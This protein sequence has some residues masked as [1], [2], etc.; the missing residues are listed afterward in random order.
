MPR[1]FL[2]LTL[3]LLLLATP[4]LDAARRRVV[5]L[6]EG[7]H[8]LFVP[9][10]SYVNDLFFADGSVWM[11]GEKTA[12]LTRG[13]VAIID[14]RP[15]TT[16][17]AVMTR[18]R[19]LCGSDV[20]SIRCID[21]TRV[22]RDYPLDPATDVV[23]GLADSASGD[24]WFADRANDRL[25]SISP[26]GEIRTW[27][28]PAG[29]ARPR[30]I[31]VDANGT[32]WIVSQRS[33]GRV[34]GD[35]LY[36]VFQANALFEGR[37]VATFTDTVAI[38]VE[39]ALWLGVSREARTTGATRGG[40]IVRMTPDGVFTE[41]VPLGIFA[42]PVEIAAGRDGSAWAVTHHVYFG[43][44]T[45]RLL[46]VWPDGRVQEYPL[47]LQTGSAFPYR[48]AG[49]TLDVDGNVWVGL[50]RPF[51][52]GALV[53]KI[54]A[55]AT[56]PASDPATRSAAATSRCAATRDP[57]SAPSAPAGPHQR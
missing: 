42:M 22:V 24:L 54:T 55:S 9:G 32:V 18:D 38:G 53:A 34:I 12:L 49:L 51:G 5:R 28:L 47:P 1:S 7:D 46:Q 4:Q 41:V 16:S 52:D 56:A 27:K 57:A 19:G 33:V 43:L 48:V 39:G 25:G 36:D 6:P 15:A 29:L 30:A 40:A 26:F 14:E 45:F 21:A 3:S 31:A 2:V 35:G 13:D 50:N 44:E 20:S 11:R 23:S 8:S 17:V 10:G 37:P